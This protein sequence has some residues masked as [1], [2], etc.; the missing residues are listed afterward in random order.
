MLW[1]N[2]SYY[3]PCLQ[4]AIIISHIVHWVL[5]NA[6][7]RESTHVGENLSGSELCVGVRICKIIDCTVVR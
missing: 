6:P 7:F 3:V 5:T 1:L 4:V 2:T